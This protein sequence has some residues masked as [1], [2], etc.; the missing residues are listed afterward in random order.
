MEKARSTATPQAGV[1]VTE[2][3]RR[4]KTEELKEMQNRL[5]RQRVIWADFRAEKGDPSNEIAVG[6]DVLREEE[7]GTAEESATMTVEELGER[8][9]DV[10]EAFDRERRAFASWYYRWKAQ[11]TQRMNDYLAAFRAGP[12]S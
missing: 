9:D 4:L 11:Q 12:W 10:E 6:I 3:T 7:V 5:R 8:F 1:L 2:M